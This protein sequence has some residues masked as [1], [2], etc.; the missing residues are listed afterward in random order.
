MRH[1]LQTG[2]A[3]GLTSAAITTLGLMVGLHS[4]THSR[5]VVLGGILTIAIAD[6]FSD[7]LGIHVSEEAENVHTKAQIWG[8]TLSAFLSKLVFAGT[9]AV[10]VLLLP[11]SWALI[12]SIA[13][14]IT[15]LT[16]LSWVIA[17]RQN[18]PRW[19]T[20]GEHLLI[21]VAVVALTHYVG[22]WVGQL[23]G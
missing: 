22:H 17:S 19:K 5:M 2:V 8:A 14:G 20:V 1:A 3:F 11:L 21:A 4:G 13:W 15:I 18:N 23:G 16:V 10:P 6:A 9:F 7:A 12:V